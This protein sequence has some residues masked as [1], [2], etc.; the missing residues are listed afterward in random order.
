MNESD[1]ESIRD[2]LP[3]IKIIYVMRNPVDRAWSH[4]KYNNKIDERLDRLDTFFESEDVSCRADYLGTVERWMSRFPNDQ[5]KPMFYD[6]LE[7]DPVRFLGEISNF[8]EVDSR[9]FHLT[10]VKKR[11]NASNSSRMSPAV[12]LYLTRKY[13]GLN[14]QLHLRFG[15]YAS[16]WLK[17]SDDFLGRYGVDKAISDSV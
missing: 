17:D 11:I 16:K 12:R 9:K 13:Y 7:S 6:L 1:I 15:G 10:Y 3:D 5:F 2:F 8:L 4:F 14:T